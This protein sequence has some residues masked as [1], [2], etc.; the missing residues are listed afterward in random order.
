MGCAQCQGQR[1]RMATA[2][3]TCWEWRRRCFVRLR[4]RGV[5]PALVRGCGVGDYLQEGRGRKKRWVIFNCDRLHVLISRLSVLICYHNINL[6]NSN[7]KIS[8]FSEKT[9][10][11]YNTYADNS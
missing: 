10:D 1:S 6:Q 5:D 11:A 9:M 8:K 7:L 4:R 2:T 3:I